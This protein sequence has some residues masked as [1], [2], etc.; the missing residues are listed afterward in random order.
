MRD[1][2]YALVAVFQLSSVISVVDPYSS[3]LFASCVSGDLLKGG[4]RLTGRHSSSITFAETPESVGMPHNVCCYT[5]ILIL[6]RFQ[7]RVPET[8]ALQP[9]SLSSATPSIGV[10]LH[11]ST[12]HISC[13][14]CMMVLHNEG[15]RSDEVGSRASAVTPSPCIPL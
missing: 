9:R 10:R 1:G 4:G 7:R 5:N 11:L 3:E 12:M 13:C 15:C 2:V 8:A 6:V 14:L